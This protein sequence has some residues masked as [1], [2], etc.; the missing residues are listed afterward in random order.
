MK[1]QIVLLLSIAL[2][3][4]GAASA[5]DTSDDLT[6]YERN[7]IQI[8]ESAS[9][10]VVHIQAT[11]AMQ[12]VFEKHEIESGT[13]S[14]FVIG[15]EGYVLTAFHVIKG[16]NVIDV[17]LKSGRRLRAQVIGTAPQID[18]ALLKI[19]APAEEL[20]PLTLGTSSRLKVGQKVLAIGNPAGMH[21]TLTVGVV[22]ALKR[23]L[24]GDLPVELQASLIQTDAAINPGNSGG[25]LLDSRGQVIGLNNAVL[26]NTQN[27]G[28]AV[29][30]DLAKRVLPDLISMGHP[31][32]AM[33]GFS[34]IDLTPELKLLFGL[35]V[36]RGLLVQEVVPNGPGAV[37]G[38]RAGDRVIVVADRPHVLGGDIIVAAAGIRTDTAPELAKVLF[39]AKPNQAIRLRI[40]RAGAELELMLQLDPMQMQF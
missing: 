4:S 11:L 34:V 16:R 31:Y 33:L 38:L 39:D 40:L 2:A 14:G 26:N 15:K 18:L 12:S 29:P 10:G 23:D 37:A 9:R 28:F 35:P 3:V 8:F 21:D 1:S 32:R 25:P 27:I 19:S 6:A 36:E 7:T 13:G 22:S 30:V 17:T 24:G 5:Q 20:F